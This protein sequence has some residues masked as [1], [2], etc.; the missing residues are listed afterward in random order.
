MTNHGEISQV[1]DAM[2]EGAY[3]YLAKPFQADDLLNRL[4]RIASI[5]DMRAELEQ[6]RAALSN[7]SPESLL[8]GQSAPMRRLL[9]LIETVAKS[10][11]ATLISGESG[12]SFSVRAKTPPPFEIRLLS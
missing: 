1:V 11:A 10:D 3:D 9:S 12:I 6:A 2:K 4:N 8:V 5:R 7:Q